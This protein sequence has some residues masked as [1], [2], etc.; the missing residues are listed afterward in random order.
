MGSKK[1]LAGEQSEIIEWN[2]Q[3]LVILLFNMLKL[4]DMLRSSAY[5]SEGGV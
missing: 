4:F 1:Q 3:I 5:L 2:N